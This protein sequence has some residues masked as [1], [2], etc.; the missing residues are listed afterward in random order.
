MNAFSFL[1]VQ[2]D[3][4]AKGKINKRDFLYLAVRLINVDIIKIMSY[5]LKGIF[6]DID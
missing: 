2:D 5:L 3:M 4:D 6:D 1:L